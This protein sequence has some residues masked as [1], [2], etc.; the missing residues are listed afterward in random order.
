[1]IADGRSIGKSI[2]KK[3]LHD[4]M[5]EQ[6]IMNIFIRKDEAAQSY[7]YLFVDFHLNFLEFL[8]IVPNS[9]QDK[10]DFSDGFNYSRFW[11]LLSP[12]HNKTWEDV[13]MSSMNKS[14]M[15][16]QVTFH[17]RNK[18]SEKHLPI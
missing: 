10:V 12:F 13:D 7:P 14:V 3:V 2:V 16:G 9:L 6:P 18:S 4:S 8:F 15:K 17:K 1:M 11:G 5:Q